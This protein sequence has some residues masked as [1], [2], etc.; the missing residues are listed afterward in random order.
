MVS[1]V[2][3]RIISVIAVVSLV[4]SIAASPYVLLFNIRGHACYSIVAGKKIAVCGWIE[5]SEK[6]V[7]FVA[8]VGEKVEWFTLVEEVYEL[9][10]IAVLGEKLVVCGSWFI[11]S[12]D[13][14]NGDLEWGYSSGTWLNDLLILPNMN[15]FVCG[16]GYVALL[17]SSG[18]IL[19]ERVFNVVRPDGTSAKPFFFAATLVGDKVVL[20]G[21]VFNVLSR[22][23][24]LD[25]LVVCISL[26]DLKVLWAKCFGGKSHDRLYGVCC[27]DKLIYVTGHTLSHFSLRQEAV[28]ACFSTDGEM[29][30]CR[31]LFSKAWC[32]GVSVFSAQAVYVVGL[33]ES[34]GVKKTVFVAELAEGNGDLLEL[35]E[36]KLGKYTTLT[37]G[38]HIEGL[39]KGILVSCSN[40]SPL[41]VYWPLG[42]EGSFKLDNSSKLVVERGKFNSSPWNAAIKEVKISV[43][44]GRMLFKENFQVKKINVEIVQRGELPV[45]EEKYLDL[46]LILLTL[47][48]AVAVLLLLFKRFKRS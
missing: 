44:V 4:L 18:K 34:Y 5:S 24:G 38:S 33:S 15:I 37:L 47:V 46:R 3:L 7:G 39:S 26:K 22:S 1:S 35:F 29:K 25:C 32:Y 31:V 2:Y 27:K 48:C 10:K 41:V 21:A 36:V 16:V 17:S 23:S 20:A 28:V 11:G 12:F 19:L 45:L 40:G 30:W 13:L 43:S 42:F 8:L 9:R 6:P 14:W